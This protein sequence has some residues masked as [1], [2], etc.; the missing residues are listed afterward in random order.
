MKTHLSIAM[1]TSLALAAP[2]VSAQDDDEDESSWNVSVLMGAAAIPT[3]LGDDDLQLTAFPD[4]RAEYKDIFFVSIAGAGY[5][6]FG[7]ENWRAGPII[8]FD[9]GRDE[10]EG[11]PLNLAGD[12]TI[13]LLGLGDIDA[14]PEVGAFFVYDNDQWELGI[15][16]RQ[17]LDGGH[18]G[19]LIS[20]EAKYK[21]QFN[22]FG[23]PAFFSFG[24]EIVYGDENYQQTYFGIT[25]EQSVGSGLA[26]YEADAGLVSAGLH[27]NLFVPIN[28]RWA[29]GIF[30]G[31]DQLGDPASDSP[32][33]IERGDE[34]QTVG[35][36]F[37]SYTF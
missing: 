31:V 10:L 1:C 36:V 8:R 3:Y 6:A 11:N 19:L 26:I 4:I 18:E 28:Q 34:T 14:S 30:A 32:L 29:W 27:G 9:F 24:P 13:D 17:G 16:A 20:A 5:N 2:L 23:K 7:G 21:G 22:L 12:E 35:G 37:L 33:I 25:P 15:E